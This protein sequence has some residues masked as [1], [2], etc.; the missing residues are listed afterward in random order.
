M[1]F[2][3]L[4]FDYTLLQ[5]SYPLKAASKLANFKEI[6]YGRRFKLANDE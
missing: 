1:L 2:F 5:Y 6:P 3:E 4:L